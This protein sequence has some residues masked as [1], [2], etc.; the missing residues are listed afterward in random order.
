MQC[1][2]VLPRVGIAIPDERMV[3]PRFGI[4]IP[5]DGCALPRFRCVRPNAGCALPGDHFAKP[6]FVDADTTCEI[7]LVDGNW[8]SLRPAVT[9][10]SQISSGPSQRK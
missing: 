9:P 8:P 5:D 1:R 3:L 2:C 7:A 10:T 6:Y 4:T